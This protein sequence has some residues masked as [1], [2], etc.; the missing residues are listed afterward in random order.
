MGSKRQIFIFISLVFVALLGFVF[1]I[2]A[3]D[4]IPYFLANNTEKKPPNWT[5]P[6]NVGTPGRRQVA[7]GGIK[8]RWT[9]PK[10]VGTPGRRQVSAGGSRGTCSD[11]LATQK[12]EKGTLTAL[13]PMA[14]EGR[15]NSQH[16]T[17][18]VY[19]PYQSKQNY[20]YEF[21]LKNQD[22][23]DIYR[24][25]L[26]IKP[27]H[28]I[29][30]ITL[31]DDISLQ[32]GQIYFWTFSFIFESANTACNPTKIAVT[33]TVEGAISLDKNPPDNTLLKQLET[34]SME[35]KITIYTEQGW[36]YDALASLAQLRRE[37]PDNFEIKSAW[38]ELL[39]AEKLEELANEKILP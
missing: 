6:Q 10:N 14:I 37:Y 34:A 23:D 27:S 19:L 4:L 36:W 22:E 28:G 11:L 21:I 24:V 30:C 15:T 38:T 12:N 13:V 39:K 9:P 7:A 35:E 2:F 29:I 16:P 5:P 1:T 26:P 3:K 18:F 8:I 33:E 20:N 31:P 25:K 32:R 17:F